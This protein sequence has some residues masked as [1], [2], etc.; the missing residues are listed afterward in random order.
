MLQQA[1]D[2]GRALGTKREIR[3][4]GTSERRETN[5]H[6]GARHRRI[7]PCSM[8]EWSADFLPISIN[9]QVLCRIAI[10]VISLSDKFF[11]ERNII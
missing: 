1:G 2:W 10:L 5:V 11:H 9:V 8:V 6:S 3:T 4:K 7:G